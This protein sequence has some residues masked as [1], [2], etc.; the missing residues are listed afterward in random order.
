MFYWILT[1]LKA[2]GISHESSL[3]DSAQ[4]ETVLNVLAESARELMR[5]CESVQDEEAR[6]NFLLTDGKQMFATRW[7]N[8]LYFVQREGVRDCQVC[9]I[10]HVEPNPQQTYRAVVIASEPISDE[11]WQEI[12]NGSVCHVDHQQNFRAT[13][14]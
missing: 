6:L 8:S 3:D 7:N 11:P 2:A 14:L 4:S 5:R 12:E 10:A 9:Q 13:K 1:R